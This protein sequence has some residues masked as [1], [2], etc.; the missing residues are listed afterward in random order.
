MD[1]ITR[2]KIVT[3]IVTLAE[4]LDKDDIVWLLWKLSNLETSEI[5]V[6][7]KLPN[8]GRIPAIFDT[9]DISGLQ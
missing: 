7:N 9:A 1:E 4:E 5:R 2:K 3:C 8:S 6:S